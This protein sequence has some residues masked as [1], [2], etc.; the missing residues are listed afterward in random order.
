[1]IWSYQN[2]ATTRQ[3][4]ILCGWS[5]RLEQSTSGHSFGTYTLLS[6]TCSRHIF[7][8]VPT[9]LDNFPE[10]KQQTLYSAIVVTLAM[11][12]RL[13][14]CRFI[15]I[16]N[17]YMKIA[18]YSHSNLRA[19]ARPMVYQNRDRTTPPGGAIPIVRA[20]KALL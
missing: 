10:Y 7:S 14:N 15:I 8:L 18:M 17:V 16:I 11:F 1:M 3:P 5:G 9:S 12:L 19:Q 2:K 13:I 6:K 20:T 4:G